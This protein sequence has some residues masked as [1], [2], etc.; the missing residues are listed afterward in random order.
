[1]LVG[2]IVGPVVGAALGVLAIYVM[3]KKY[4]SNATIMARMEAH[5]SI[6]LSTESDI[7]RAPETLDQVVADLELDQ[8]WAVSAEDARLRLA[9]MIEVQNIRGTD[10]IE[11]RTRTSNQEEAADITNSVTAAYLSRRKEF[12]D[13]NGETVPNLSV[14]SDASNPAASVSPNA[15]LVLLIGIAAGLILGMLASVVLI[16]VLHRLF[17]ARQ[18]ALA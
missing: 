7:I 3:P 11:I 17:P 10:M 14:I 6:V 18:P 13:L 16:P 9:S 2:L 1:M 15:T 5:D 4:E 12:S 8:R